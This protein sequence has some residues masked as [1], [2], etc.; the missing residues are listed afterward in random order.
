MECVRTEDEEDEPRLDN[1][2]RVYSSRKEAEEEPADTDFCGEH[3]RYR[4][5]LIEEEEN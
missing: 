2:G 5:G 4:K 3:G 1:R